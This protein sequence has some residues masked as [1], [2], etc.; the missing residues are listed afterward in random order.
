MKVFVCIGFSLF[1]NNASGGM[2]LRPS[3][4]CTSTPI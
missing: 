4:I 3:Q 1:R 2:P